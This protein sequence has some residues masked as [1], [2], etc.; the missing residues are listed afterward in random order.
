MNKAIVY[1]KRKS[2]AQYFSIESLFYNIIEE[3][4]KSY[5]TKLIKTKYYGGS[6][7]VIINNCL[8]F[9]R[10]PK[11]IYH[12]TGDVHY[13]ALATRK[14]TILTIHD[15]GSALKGSFFKRIYVKL[16]WFWLPALFVRRI[17]V[18]SEFTKQELSKII[19]FSKHKIRVVYN[20]VSLLYV[21]TLNNFNESCP[22]IL[23]VGTKENKNLERIFEAV[24]NL[25]CQLHIIGKL[26]VNQISIL[27]DNSIDYSNSYNLSQ[28]EIIKA[29]KDCDILCFP[30]TYEG[31]GMPIIEAQ[32]TGR[33]VIT[34]NF[35]AMKE[36][37]R[38]S[39][40]LVDAFDVESI[41]N[42]I[43]NI[44]S[45]SNYRD[46]II[47][48]GLENVKRFQLDRIAKQYIEIYKELGL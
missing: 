35:G 42:G 11:S 36:I 25:S 44:I 2:Q 9:K 30:S 34:S 24:I 6:P 46:G 18:I 27:E 26:S 23:C 29:Y 3:V 41:K 17:T 13:V 10:T 48:K 19:P 7:L 12:I 47:N 16:F 45:D 20:P 14:R 39:A 5:E 15:I 32:A 31:F 4:S 43:Q 38:D 8:T 21:S 37:S 1:I 28:E 33:P 40:C 22:K